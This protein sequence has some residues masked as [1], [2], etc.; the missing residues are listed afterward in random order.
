MLQF[1]FPLLFSRDS[2]PLSSVYLFLRVWLFGAKISII[3]H[4]FIPNKTDIFF[5]IF[6]AFSS[7]NISSSILYLSILRFKVKKCYV[8]SFYLAS[9]T[10]GFL[11]ASKLDLSSFRLAA[12]LARAYVFF[13]FFFHGVFVRFGGVETIFTLWAQGTKTWG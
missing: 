1:R 12:P 9:F 13:L 5:C 10:T 11:I 6:F 7:C 8:F 4:Y 2:P 3:F